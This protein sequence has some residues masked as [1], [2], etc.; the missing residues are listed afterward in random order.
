LLLLSY[1]SFIY[2]T[3]FIIPFISYSFISLFLLFAFSSKTFGYYRQ[4]VMQI[5]N[6]DISA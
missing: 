4:F 1:N 5:P 2:L 3:G 6:S